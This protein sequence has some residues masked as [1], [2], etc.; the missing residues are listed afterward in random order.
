LSNKTGRK[1][2]RHC[3]ALESNMQIT[4]EFIHLIA[5]LLF[6]GAMFLI[7]LFVKAG[8]TVESK[9]ENKAKENRKTRERIWTF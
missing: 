5:W 2:R 3:A 6:G 7:Y 1:I 9:A 4:L 8:Q